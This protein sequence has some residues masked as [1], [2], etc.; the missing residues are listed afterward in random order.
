MLRLARRGTLGG[1]GLLDGELGREAAHV[2]ARLGD[3]GERDGSVPGGLVVVVAGDR[4]GAGYVDVGLRE[5]LD[6][7]CGEEVGGGDDA[8]DTARANR[9]QERAG[10][11]EAVGTVDG[12]GVD[13]EHRLEPRG[14]EDRTEAGAAVVDRA[15]LVRAADERQAAPA[16]AQEVLG[17][18]ARAEHVVDGD[19]AVAVRGR[20]EVHEDEGRLARG[21]LRDRGHVLVVGQRDEGARDAQLAEHLQVLELAAD[22]V[23]AVGKDHVHARGGRCRPGAARDVDE[24]RVAQVGEHEAEH[25]GPTGGQRARDAVG[26]VAELGHGALDA[27]ARGRGDPARVVEDVRDGAG[28]DARTPRHLAH[29]GPGG[30]PV[31]RG[32]RHGATLRPDGGACAVSEARPGL[33]ALPGGAARAAPPRAR[34]LPQGA[35]T[36]VAGVPERFDWSPVRIDWSDRSAASPSRVCAGQEP[37]RRGDPGDRRSSQSMRT[38]D[39][40]KRT[41]DRSDRP[42]SR[43]ERVGHARSAANGSA[44]AA[45][46]GPRRRPTARD[47]ADLSPEPAPGRS[48]P[49]PAR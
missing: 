32:A 16:G 11:L 18:E 20:R 34:S 42:R 21:G 40:S 49:P 44:R 35:R 7:A 19:A 27:L 12:R 4:D 24:Q 2:L 41:G 30:G 39:Q 38:G 8:V 43:S 47:R 13:L 10:G 31:P 15:K 33:P 25:A 48:G 45:A 23:V 1:A 36:G 22:V 9:G 5:G 6:E 14:G 46:R 3:R 29:R 37:C 28:G 17:G 26:A